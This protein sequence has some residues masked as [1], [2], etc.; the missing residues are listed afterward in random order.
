MAEQTL[1]G[2][3]EMA[4]KLSSDLVNHGWGEMV[5]RVSSLKDNTVKVEVLC[6]KS[7]VF[8]IKKSIFNKEI[9]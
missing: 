7:Y 8:F 6:G 1:T 4:V 9:L 2:Y 3:H 5:F